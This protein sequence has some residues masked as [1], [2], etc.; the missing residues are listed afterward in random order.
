LIHILLR[1]KEGKTTGSDLELYVAFYARDDRALGAQNEY[2][3]TAD[4]RSGLPK[5]VYDLEIHGLGPTIKPEI[6]S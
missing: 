1:D 3:V 4:E 6:P 5:S 2:N